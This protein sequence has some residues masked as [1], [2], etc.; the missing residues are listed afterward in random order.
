VAV[1][2]WRD[3]G[4]AAIVAAWGSPFDIGTDTGGSIR[5]PAHCC[6]I[7]GLKPTSGRVSRAGHIIN[8]AGHAQSLTTVGPLARHVEDL[9]LLLPI[10]AGPDELDPHV[11]PVPLRDPGALDVA[12]LRVATYLDIG[13][14]RAEAAVGAAVAA[15]AGVLEEAGAT[16]RE[17][18][19]PGLEQ[20]IAR[21]RQS[22]RDLDLRVRCH[23]RRPGPVPQPDAGLHE[24]F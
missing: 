18:Q 5:Y 20:S 19:P 1:D 9:E 3:G 11:V 6:G 4:A 16:I 15:A 24:R 7:A 22:G 10:I 2:C 12:G 8:F 14:I 17:A 13:E 23:T 21:G